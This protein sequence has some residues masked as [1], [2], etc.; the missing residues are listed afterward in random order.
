MQ[1]SSKSALSFRIGAF[2][3]IAAAATFLSG[4]DEGG[5]GSN[6]RAYA[7][8]APE[9]LALMKEKDTTKAAPVLIRTYKKESEL[10]IWKM[11]S[12]GR[13]ALLKT[14][15]VCRWSGQLGPKTREG[16]RQ[17]PEG[18]YSITPA[19]MKP[20]SAYYLAFNVGYPNAYDR[21]LGHD[22][23][24]IM[25]HGICS[26]AGCF[27]MTDPQI[28]EIY[29]IVRE[30][31]SAG[32]REVQ[33]QSY[34]FRMTAENMAKYRLD[35][36]IGF[37]KQ[38][39]EGSDNFEVTQQEVTVG[40]CSKHYVF[41]ATPVN[42][43]FDP[44]GPCPQLKQD[45]GVRNLVA[46]KETRDDAKVAELAAQG[47]KPVRTVYADGGGHPSFSSIFAYASRPDALARGP[48]DIALDEGKARKG[49]ASP[50]VQMAAGKLNASAPDVKLADARDVTGAIAPTAPAKE[51]EKPW[52]FVHLFGGE[53]PAEPAEPA[54]PAPVAANEPLVPQFADVPLPPHRS[55]SAAR[56][57]TTSEGTSSSNPALAQAEH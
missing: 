9:T 17:V 15:P 33:M 57:A 12:D 6:S 51:A 47:V 18:F 11:K 36:N 22:G 16:D 49:R 5:L 56:P 53:K 35:P 1:M 25:V 13:Y 29:A 32:Q 52:M 21:A 26:S 41:N 31:F 7:P 20:N 27:S 48:I 4:C 46:A 40:V 37:W 19:Q 44:D 38:L 30:G 45:E 14:Y 3:L 34:P 43:R 55:D 42:G 23:G 50:V 39:K 10:E 2:A 54:A 24:S 8:I 28:G